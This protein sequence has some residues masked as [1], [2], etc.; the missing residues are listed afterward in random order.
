MTKTPD[1]PRP[2][3]L[4][5]LESPGEV[6]TE[7]ERRFGTDYRIVVTGNV[8]DAVGR[9][10]EAK[11][12]GE[13]VALVLG[14]SADAA[15]YVE[16]RRHHPDARRGFVL[17]WGA[18]ATQQTSAAVLSLMAAN[19]IDYYVVR[20]RASP[21]ESFNRGITD[22][23]RDYQ[24]AT[25][26][27][28]IDVTMTGG[29]VDLARRHGLSTELPDSGVDV[30]IVGAGPAGLAAAVYAA[31][32]GLDTLVIERRAVGG[33]AGSSSL[34]R[35]YLGF[36]RGVSGSELAERAYQQAW[37]FGARFAVT[38]EVVGVAS[39]DGG[40][41]LEVAPGELVT[42]GAVVLA[43]GV[44]YRRL[45]LPGLAGFLGTSV[46]YGVSALEA[47]AQTARVVYVVG[48]GNSAG[49]AALHLARYAASVSLVVRGPNLAA[50]MSQYLIDELAAAGVGIVTEAK[51]VGGGGSGR[52][53]TI[54]LRDRVTGRESS[55]R[56][57]ALFI[58]IGAAPHTDW[59]PPEVL[60][61]RWGYVLTG[62][63]IVAE[64]G[65]RAWPHERAP[66]ALETS[67]AGL[68]A[69]GDVRRASIKRVASAVGEG[70]VVV[71]AVHQHLAAT[72]SPL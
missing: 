25:A 9:V 27:D 50:S 70:S 21:D 46:F 66:G 68:F 41:V 1:R 32:E 17:A 34:I 39:A 12:V 23:L 24:R 59:L 28:V 4:L 61:D 48:G 30:A 3:I 43:A 57:D 45:A 8:A 31:S 37:I 72:R 6:A 2:L 13:E 29:S 44:S 10:R 60:R 33:Q 11:S 65:R 53:E 69:V 20:P 35:N 38:R 40:F 67:L 36:S 14:D 55:V 19:H 22:F 51:V 7:L 42:A 54:T 64:G 18:W 62:A 16:T 58:T 71:S 49:Q 26:T 15:L 56:C 52:L 63:E 5:S 47:R